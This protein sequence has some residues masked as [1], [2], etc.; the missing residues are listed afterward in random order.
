VYRVGRTIPRQNQDGSRGYD[1]LLELHANPVIQDECRTAVENAG[2][3]LEARHLPRKGNH[4]V[5]AR[6]IP[7]GMRLAFYSG[8]VERADARHAR[9][10]EMHMGEVGLGF[11]VTIDSD[12]TPGLVPEDDARPGW[13]RQASNRK[14]CMQPE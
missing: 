14:S 7:A 13:T 3:Y 1:T 10:R 4:C 2:R 9:D 5:A 11:E 12:G 8:L 6:N